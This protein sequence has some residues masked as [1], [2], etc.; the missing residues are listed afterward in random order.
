MPG[1]REEGVRKQFAAM[2]LVGTWSVGRC[3]LEAHAESRRGRGVA[4][5]RGTIGSMNARRADKDEDR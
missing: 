3:L 4:E 1:W 2:M 5:N